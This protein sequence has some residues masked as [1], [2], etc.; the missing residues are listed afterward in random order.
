[1]TETYFC[2]GKDDVFCHITIMQNPSKFRGTLGEYCPIQT[3]DGSWTLWSEAFDENCHSLSG[4]SLETK[5]NY[6]EATK[7]KEK[8]SQLQVLSI[9]EVGFATGQGATL[10]YEA[11][12]PH[13][14]NHFVRFISLEIDEELVKWAINHSSKD[15]PVSRLLKS[16]KDGIN[17][18]RFSDSAFELIVIIGDARQTVVQIPSVLDDHKID[19]IYQ[20]PFS[21]KKNRNLW[22][23]EWFRELSTISSQ[24]V[25]LSTYSASSA[26]RK[27]LIEAGWFPKSRQ[28]FSGKRES[29]VATLVGEHDPILLE[30]LSRSPLS[31]IFDDQDKTSPLVIS[32]C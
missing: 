5:H 2:L 23:V 19:A 4:A 3:A 7:V 31:S 10:T 32:D 24:T 13:A 9:L 27:S 16:S 22:T 12:F 29:T 6:I 1:M 28:G 8:Y 25:I 30:H 20:D 15:G 21:P 17:S 26:V 11:L 18:Y 14:S